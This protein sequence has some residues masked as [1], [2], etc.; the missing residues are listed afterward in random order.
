MKFLFSDRFSFFDMAAILVV[1]EIAQSTSLWWLL[2]VLPL[3]IIGA[4]MSIKY[5]Q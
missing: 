3:S 1:I 5:G 4:I 2:A